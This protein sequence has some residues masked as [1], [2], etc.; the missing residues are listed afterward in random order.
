MAD[1]IQRS[2]E[3][4]EAR[5]GKATASRFNDIMA[6]GAAG[7]PLA[8]WKNYKAE[9]L[10]ERLTGE[11]YNNFQSKEM[12]WGIETEPL[13]RLY[14]TLS[15]GNQVEEVGFMEHEQMLAGASPDGFIGEQGGLEIK[16]PN[17]ATH[18]ETLHTKAVPRQ[19]VAQVQGNM[20]ITG[21]KWWD[22]VSFDPRMPENAKYIMIKVP[23][24][25]A[26][27]ESLE[28]KVRLFLKEVAEEVEFV[29]NYGKEPKR[30]PARPTTR[31]RKQLSNK[32]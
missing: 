8:G 15:T 23:R 29:N 24:D 4:Y 31:T 10:I 21:R 26:Y 20:W 3:W 12:L 7:K 2:P 17:P 6:T 1:M 13:A 18:I 11:P 14:Y 27:I 28:G 16:C 30:E 19:Y 22:F 32:G 5:L 9:L 25:D